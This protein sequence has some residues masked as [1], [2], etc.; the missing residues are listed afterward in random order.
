LR[1]SKK[2]LDPLL[3]NDDEIGDWTAAI[4]KQRSLNY[5]GMVFSARS[6]KQT[7]V[8]QQNNSDIYGDN[9]EVFYQD[10]SP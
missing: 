10:K 1:L 9:A 6:A 4:A 7:I 2:K 5:R 3:V 8:L